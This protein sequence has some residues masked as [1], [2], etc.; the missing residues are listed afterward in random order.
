MS[1]SSRI[2]PVA[3][4]STMAVAVAVILVEPAFAQAAGIETILFG[5]YRCNKTMQNAPRITKVR[6]WKE[7]GE[8][9][10]GR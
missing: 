3:A 5:D 6:N 8:Y 4:P 1:I 2:R 7:V 10:D 9:F